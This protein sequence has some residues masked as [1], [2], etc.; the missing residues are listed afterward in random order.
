MLV[1][2]CTITLLGFI[3]GNVR[4]LFW[5]NLPQHQKPKEAEQSGVP[6]PEWCLSDAGL[7]Q[8]SSLALT[9]I[10]GSLRWK[11]RLTRYCSKQAR[12]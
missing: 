3:L 12:K 8:A 1:G 11:T 9:L 7:V 2:R 5:G 4:M 10:V 6:L